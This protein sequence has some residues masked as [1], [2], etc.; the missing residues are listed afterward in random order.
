MTGFDIG[1]DARPE[2]HAIAKSEC[3]GVWGAFF[4]TREHMEAPEDHLAAA[5][6]KPVGE[7]EGAAGEGEMDGNAD[8]FGHGV[9]G[10]SAVEQVF[11][12]V[13]ET[14]MW[15][16]GCGEASEGE[17][18]CEDV[19][20]EAGIGVF[21]VEGIDQQG[22]ARLDG[23]G[24]DG[25]EERG[26][27]HGGR[28]RGSGDGHRELYNTKY[29]ARRE[30]EPLGWLMA[31]LSRGVGDK[32]VA[33]KDGLP[34]LGFATLADWE[35][36]LAK[37]NSSSAGVWVKFA[38]ARS[39]VKTISKREA[40]D[41]A[42]C[43]GWIDGQLQ[44][45]DE[46]HW[47]VRFTPRKARS[48]WSQ[49]NRS[50]AQELIEAGKMRAGGLAEIERT[51]QEGR[52]EEAYASQSKIE[53]PED[54]KAALAASPGAAKLFDQL[55]SANRYSVL[56][57]IT[58]AKKPET[59]AARIEKIVAMLERGETFHPRRQAKRSRS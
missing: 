24:C 16:R 48:K 21:R 6:T 51:K 56:Y 3:I 40:I 43:H 13:A 53:V 10:R 46:R 42:L 58:Q 11:V 59:R 9:D 33:V 28:K 55:D 32:V 4:R 36:W 34:I 47:L 35:E 5:G 29:I 26:L 37:Q 39:G 52:W 45:F 15:R 38:K 20:A 41:G 50:R 57:R 23:C 14:P 22:I 1:E 17:S 30:G 19:L 8:D 31:K 25:G 7:L 27:G 54:W 12:P 49:V 44:P 18:G 2:L